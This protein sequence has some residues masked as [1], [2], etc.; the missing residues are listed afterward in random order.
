MQGWGRGDADRD[1]SHKKPAVPTVATR[2]ISSAFGFFSRRDIVQPV[3]RALHC[4]DARSHRFSSRLSPLVSLVRRLSLKLQP[5]IHP[6][7]PRSGARSTFIPAGLDLEISIG[8]WERW[9]G[10]GE[11]D[12]HH[13]P[14]Y[15]R[16]GLVGGELARR[17]SSLFYPATAR[18]C[19]PLCSRPGRSVALSDPPAEL[20]RRGESPDKRNFRWQLRATEAA[21]LTRLSPP[22]LPWAWS[23]LH[24]HLIR[25]TTV[26]TLQGDAPLPPVLSFI[27]SGG[28][29]ESSLMRAV[30]RLFASNL[31][32]PGSIPSGIAPGFLQVGIVPDDAA[33][34]RVVPFPTPFHSCAAPYS[35]RFTHI[36]SQDL[37]VTSHPDLSTSL[38]IR[39]FGIVVIGYSRRIFD[40][41]LGAFSEHGFSSAGH[42]S[43]CAMSCVCTHASNLVPSAVGRCELEMGP[44]AFSDVGRQIPDLGDPFNIEVLRAVGGEV[45]GTGMNGRDK[46]EIPEKSGIVRHNSHLRK[47]VVNRPGIE[48]SS[49]WKEASSLTAQPPPP[50]PAPLD[51]ESCCTS[52]ESDKILSQSTSAIGDGDKWHTSEVTSLNVVSLYFTALRVHKEYDH[53]ASENTST[54]R[55]GFHM[56]PREIHG[57]SVGTEKF[58]EFNNLYAR[59]HN[60]LFSRTSDVYLL[61]VAPVLPRV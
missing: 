48:P 22:P 30:V 19:R 42:H 5:L 23:T 13:A 47:F 54:I 11:A 25:F 32:E 46:R 28:G 34:R 40:S 37:D 16:C 52:E 57:L 20:G 29:E 18:I 14:C 10:K 44:A 17:T 38:H 36:G 50:P 15:G 53:A 45:S 1:G 4:A 7:T 3:N 27:T 51:S 49:S 55:T 61:A 60:P 35:P 33:G 24:P 31:G 39:T 6:T 9:W 12:E 8:S 2:L 58:R 21:C 59:L 56:R 43:A 41:V 26:K